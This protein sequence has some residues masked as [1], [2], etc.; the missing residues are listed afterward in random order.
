MPRGFWCRLALPSPCGRKSIKTRVRR[1]P[2]SR[3]DA[4]CSAVHAPGLLLLRHHQAV[5]AGFKY[6]NRDPNIFLSQNY[7]PLRRM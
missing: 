1:A 4:F 5:R 7:K 6:L 3:N 2:S